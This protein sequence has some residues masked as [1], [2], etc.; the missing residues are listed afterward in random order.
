MVQALRSWWVPLSCVAFILV[1][2]LA[3]A[4]EF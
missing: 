4:H 2:M 3:T 1:N